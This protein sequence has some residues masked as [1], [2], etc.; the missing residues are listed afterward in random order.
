MIRFHLTLHQQQTGDLLRPINTSPASYAQPA[1]PPLLQRVYDLLDRQPPGVMVNV[2]WLASKL[3]VNR[4]TLYRNVMRLTQLS[5]AE[6][7]RH[8]YLSKAA[9]LIYEGYT[10]AETAYS[11]GFNTPSHFTAV[12]K[13][14]YGQTPKQFRS[15]YKM[16]PI[17]Q[18]MSPIG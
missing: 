15:A 9:S 16:P 12:F 8:Y 6:M 3:A 10:I 13:E 4:K 5:P 7:L 1:V 17:R 11:V 18:Y 2:D 14:Q